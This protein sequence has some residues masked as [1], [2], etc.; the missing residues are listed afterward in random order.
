M[1]FAIRAFAESFSL[2]PDVSNG[3]SNWTNSNATVPRPLGNQMV[4]KEP[5]TS[6]VFKVLALAIVIILSLVGNFL[7]ISSVYQNINRRMRTLSNYL[8]VN[9][10]VADLLVT[11][12][13]IPRIISILLVGYEWLIR[14][15]FAL[16]L[17]K[18]T[19]AV[20]FVALL[21]ST[22]SFTFIALDRFLAVFYPLRRPMTRKI[23]VGIIAFTWIL[24]CCCYALVF[25]YATLVEINGKTYCANRI[26]RD[27]LKSQEN[28]RT[29]LICDFIIVTGIPIAT[30]T[31]LYIVIGVKMCTRVTPGNQTLTPYI[32]PVFNQNF[33]EGY[34]HAL[35]QIA[36][37][38]CFRKICQRCGNNQVLPSEER[39]TA[40]TASRTDRTRFN[41][42]EL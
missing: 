15:K 17:C 34:L 41:T 39:T 40:T 1:S 30:T 12:C 31:I 8:I 20:P 25:H 32:Y 4:V 24:S 21:V 18:V 38:C 11:V 14:G 7:T 26:V 37:C 33:R 10:S 19:S 23:M 5:L 42:T 27:L 3:S 6:T 36:S 35:R 16:F 2:F 28:F 22:L 9:L 13:N 29:Y